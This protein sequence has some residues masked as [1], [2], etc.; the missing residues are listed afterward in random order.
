M[1]V[2]VVTSLSSSVLNFRKE[3]LLL[4]VEEGHEVWVLAPS[5]SDNT[6]LGIEAIGCHCVCYRSAR[7]GFNPFLDMLTL[8]DLT[9]LI[10]SLK[11]NIVFSYFSKP[12]VYGSLA[13][14]LARVPRVVAMLEGLGYTY[15]RDRHGVFS[16]KHAVRV[17]QSGLYSIAFRVVDAL[18]VLN[19]DDIADLARTT[20]M[21]NKKKIHIL[22]PIGL[23]LGSFAFSPV[24]VSHRLRFIFIGRLIEDK[25]IYEFVKAAS[26]IKQDHANVEFVVLGNIDPSNPAS[27]SQGSLDDYTKAGVIIHK[28]HVDDVYSEIKKAHIFV[29]PSYREGFPRSTQ[30]AMS[31]GRAIITTDTA[32]C[33]DT[34][35]EGVNGFLVPVFAIEELVEKMRY[36]INNK[37]AVIEMG[38]ESYRIAYERYD[39]N[40]INTRL[41]DIVFGDLK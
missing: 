19:K 32:G 1:K 29:L 21:P 12:V 38:D 14:W 41:K 8:Y 10:R 22:G 20:W 37:K 16:F 23:D 2:V 27:L 3:F 25:G 13:G 33:R 30:E 6:K 7:G 26:L 28:G 15:T 36:F 9:T 34:V 31:V 5:F 35:K 40:K 24:D 11:P 39:V 4:L 18:I 17:I